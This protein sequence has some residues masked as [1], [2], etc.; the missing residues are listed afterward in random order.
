M[1]RVS[2]LAQATARCG[3]ARPVICFENVR[4]S[5]KFGGPGRESSAHPGN[6]AGH[7]RCGLA[8]TLAARL[9][10]HDPLTELARHLSVELDLG[11][12]GPTTVATVPVSNDGLH[13]CSL[14]RRRP[15]TDAY[16][17]GG[18]TVGGIGRNESITCPGRRRL[19]R[20]PGSG[21]R[22]PRFHKVPHFFDVDRFDQVMVEPRFP[23][24]MAVALL[25]EAGECDQ[26]AGGEILAVRPRRDDQ[27]RLTGGV[28]GLEVGIPSRRSARSAR[29]AV[30]G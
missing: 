4:K 3:P 20:G 15:A 28:A 26:D 9:D 12:V 10:S 14:S 17:K 24:E 18:G 22:S 30:R 25:T 27:E 29:D 13:G 23:R 2:R 16:R 5:G 11:R 8:A 19:R 7:L 21:R 1:G 6:A